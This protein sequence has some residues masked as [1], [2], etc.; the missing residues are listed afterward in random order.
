MWLVPLIRVMVFIAYNFRAPPL[1][2]NARVLSPP[3]TRYVK[4]NLTCSWSTGYKSDVQNLLW[5]LTQG[6]DIDILNVRKNVVWGMS[7]SWH[8]FVD[9]RELNS[10]VKILSWCLQVTTR[11]FTYNKWRKKTFHGLNMIVVKIQY[12]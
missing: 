4:K 3:E 8:N 5:K 10:F 1:E 7:Y 2:N 9:K 11:I 12:I 6:R